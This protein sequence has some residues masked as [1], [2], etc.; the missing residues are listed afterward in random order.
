MLNYLIA[1]SSAIVS[2]K[3]ADVQISLDVVAIT[4]SG[5]YVSLGCNLQGCCARWFNA[6]M[7]F[8]RLMFRLSSWGSEIP[9]QIRHVQEPSQRVEWAGKSPDRLPLH[10]RRISDY[11]PHKIVYRMICNHCYLVGVSP[12]ASA[13]FI[14]NVKEI[15]INIYFRPVQLR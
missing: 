12:V 11:T 8:S 5:R 9:Y 10:I 1:T 13:D 7:P 14:D 6:V 15:T 4:S 2:G 3:P